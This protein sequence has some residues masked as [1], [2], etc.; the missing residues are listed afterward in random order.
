MKALVKTGKQPGLTYGP[1]PDPLVGDDDVL[2]KIK[3]AAICG[4]DLLIYRWDK[5]VESFV[6]KL[7]FIPGHECAGIVQSTGANVTGIRKG[8][9]VAVETHVPC[10][11]CFQ[12]NNNMS[13]ICQNL[14]LFG[15]T[16]NGCFAEY[17]KAP[18]VSVRTIPK[19]LPFEHAA[20]LEP[21]GIALRA[22]LAAQVAGET[23]V[24]CGCGPIGLFI[25]A[26]SRY[27]GATQI[28]ATDIN[29]NRLAVAGT[30]GATALVNPTRED[31][32][33]RIL[34]LTNGIGAGA[35]MEAS[36]NAQV[37]NR[38]FNYLRKGGKLIL[39]GNSKEELKISNPVK[40]LMHKE[41][42]IKAFH[43]REMYSTWERAESILTSGRFDVSPIITHKYPLA[44]FEPGFEVA[45]S[46][47]ACKVVF[48][49]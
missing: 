12:C 26:L 15:H 19:S 10:G 44:D 34:A 32:I 37:F 48:T 36:G 14:V 43:G 47:E 5:A 1:F 24:V 31:E 39:I 45:L 11:E 30:V 9:H 49:V 18:A 35:V 17:A 8:D 29:D 4:T 25:V 33:D 27:L 2:I 23:V 20:M 41:I 13:H 7:P 21:M 46:G 28:I 40:D 22:P 38:S 6:P 16:I 3:A 42:T